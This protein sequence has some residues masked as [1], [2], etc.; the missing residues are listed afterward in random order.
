MTQRN[1]DVMDIIVSK[2]A[3]G[4]K[5]SKAL[6]RVYHKRKV[7][8]PYIEDN[9]N[10]SLMNLGMS[11]R[12]TN[13]LLRARLRTVGDVIEFCKTNKITEITN[14]GRNSGVEVFEAILDYCWD[15][16]SQ[17]ERISFLIDTVERNSEYIREEIA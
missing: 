7:A 2:M 5:L 9:L 13:A 15:H 14:L 6:Q 1:I 12:A 8:I 10:E 3:E 4:D 17:E 11:G 16:M